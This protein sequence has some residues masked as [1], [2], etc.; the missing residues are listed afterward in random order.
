MVVG[1]PLG[2]LHLGE[3]GGRESGSTGPRSPYVN[4]AALC[5]AMRNAGS[6]R[7]PRTGRGPGAVSSL[8]GRCGLE[9]RW[10]RSRHSGHNPGSHLCSRFVT[11]P[12]EFIFKSEWRSGHH[13]G[14]DRSPGNLWAAGT[15][16]SA[17]GAP[18][19]G[20]SQRGVAETTHRSSLPG[21]NRCPCP[22]HCGGATHI[23]GP[24][25]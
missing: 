15:P 3:M 9:S 14:P 12:G 10:R 8:P 1:T 22:V 25:H 19:W 13:T 24:P 18:A 20:L 11:G 16:C 7:A 21:D 6:A 5:E 4:T 2:G 23:P 17:Q